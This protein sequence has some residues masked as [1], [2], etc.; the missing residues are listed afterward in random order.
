MNSEDS[1]IGTEQYEELKL[2]LEARGYRKRIVINDQVEGLRSLIARDTPGIFR[3]ERF[4]REGDPTI[5]VI[6]DDE[7]D[8]QVWGPPSIWLNNGPDES[9]FGE[10]FGNLFGVTKP[11]D[12]LNQKKMDAVMDDVIDDF[13][14]DAPGSPANAR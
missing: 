8:I 12:P 11:A 6:I 10:Y 9:G 1:T 2:A 14:P 4:E 7:H 3:M 5:L 13:P